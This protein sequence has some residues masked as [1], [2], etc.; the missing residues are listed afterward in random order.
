M[1]NTSALPC[2]VTSPVI[3]QPRGLPLRVRHKALP[4]GL[5]D[6]ET[7]G[8]DTN[9]NTSVSAAEMSFLAARQPRE[10]GI[11]IS[12]ELKPGCF[13]APSADKDLTE[14]RSGYARRL[15]TYESWLSLDIP[16]DVDLIG[17]GDFKQALRQHKDACLRKVP[18][19]YMHI[20]VQT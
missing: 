7:S 3:N 16:L 2:G 8:A 10:H 20:R 15:V 9:S 13:F 19:L 18:S 17:S 6:D 5:S 1:D 4:E 11:R 12:G 14:C